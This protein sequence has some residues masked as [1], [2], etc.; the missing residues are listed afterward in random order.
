MSNFFSKIYSTSFGVNHQKLHP[1]SST[2]RCCNDEYSGVQHKSRELNGWVSSFPEKNL[3]LSYPGIVKP[4]RPKR[5]ILVRHGQSEGNIDESVYTR[6][7]DP[8]VGLTEKGVEEAEECGRKMREMIEKDGGDDWKVYFYVS[9]YKRGIETL[10]N[11]AKSFERS[12]IAGVREEPRLREQDFGNFQDK[13]QMKIEKAVRARYGRFFY[14]FPNGES[15][16]DV[17][18]RITVDQFEGLHNMSNGG[19]IV[20]E[21]GYGGRYCLSVHHTREELQKFGMTDEMLIDQEW[22]K[23]AKPGELNYDCLITGPSYFTHF[24]DDEDKNFEM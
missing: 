1:N 12:R 11:L 23:I 19:M 14:R 17:Y 10:R 4:P 22:Q 13:E 20:M 24:D 8:N 15:A 9:P 18:D 2:I 16:A 7:A 6:V 21:R 5:I 3:V